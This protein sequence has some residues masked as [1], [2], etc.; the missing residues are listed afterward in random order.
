MTQGQEPGALLKTPLYDLHV[1]A[2]AQMVPFAGWEMPLLYK[3]II[4]EH[5]HTRA[6]SSIFDVSHMGRIRVTGPA[7]LELLER[8]CTR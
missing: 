6:A 3:G 7:S 5:Q 2:G 4:P 1:A 8:L